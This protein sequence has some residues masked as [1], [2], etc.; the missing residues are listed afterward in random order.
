LPTEVENRLNF[1]KTAEFSA[2]SGSNSALFSLYSSLT[3]I[4]L[5][6]KI[7]DGAVFQRSALPK[8]VSPSFPL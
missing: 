1:C 4:F 5:A 7:V 6:V 8:T 3:A 2:D